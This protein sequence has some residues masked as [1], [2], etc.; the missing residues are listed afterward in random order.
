VSQ[1]S[2]GLLDSW[3]VSTDLLGR[4]CWTAYIKLQGL[5]LTLNIYPFSVMRMYPVVMLSRCY[6]AS[7]GREAKV[8][9][10]LEAFDVFKRFIHQRPVSIVFHFHLGSVRDNFASY[11][12]Q[13]RQLSSNSSAFGLTVVFEYWMLDLPSDGYIDRRIEQLE[14]DTDLSEE[15]F[16]RTVNR[17]MA[18]KSISL[19]A[20]RHFFEVWCAATRD[21]GA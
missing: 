12:G 6:Q 18:K 16:R 21:A 8:E 5:F 1:W 20:V 10:V 15:N 4:T 17:V 2:A 9:G 3:K 7:G 11:L 14:A 19:T 13:F